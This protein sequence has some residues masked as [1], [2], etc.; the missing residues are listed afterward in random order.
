MCML[1]S[2]EN[3][4]GWTNWCPNKN[5]RINATQTN[6]SF[7]IFERIFLCGKEK[8]TPFYQQISIVSKCCRNCIYLHCNVFLLLE[9]LK[10]RFLGNKKCESE[11]LRMQ[12]CCLQNILW[13][14]PLWSKEWACLEIETRNS[15]L[16]IRFKCHQLYTKTTLC[17]VPIRT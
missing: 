10:N 6:I 8:A 13:H 17:V 9:Q 7:K 11:N 1:L 2:I 5:A 16:V 14:S 15:A 4:I 12:H 3:D